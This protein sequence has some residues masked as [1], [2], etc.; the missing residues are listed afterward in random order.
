MPTLII[1]DEPVTPTVMTA[2]YTTSPYRYMQAIRAFPDGLKIITGNPTGT[3]GEI[4]GHRVWFWECGDTQIAAGNATTAPTCASV[5]TLYM[6]FPDCWDGVNLDSADHRSHMRYSSWPAPTYKPPY[7]CPPSHP[8][9][10]PQLTLRYRYPTQGGPTTRLSSGAINTAHADF[11]NA[12]RE[13]AMA[14]L[15]TDCLNVDKY[16]GGG[17]KP[18]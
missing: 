4:N 2:N 10:M 3:A 11:F 13:G 5:L 17:D 6:G 1:N 14:P 7:V 16:C 9:V 12:W 8:F 15:V 18:A